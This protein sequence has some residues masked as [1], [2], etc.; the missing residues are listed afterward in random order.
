[1]GKIKALYLK[2]KYNKYLPKKFLH[3]LVTFLVLSLSVFGFFN[4]TNLLSARLPAIFFGIEISRAFSN[5]LSSI[6]TWS[7]NSDANFPYLGFTFHKPN[8]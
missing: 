5:Q 8:N 6:Y 7:E 2:R 3:C 4:K 1:M